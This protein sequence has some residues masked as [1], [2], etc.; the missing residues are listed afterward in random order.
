MQLASPELVRIA[1]AQLLLLVGAWLMAELVR[2]LLGHRVKVSGSAMVL[3]SLVAVC[4]GV[5]VVGVFLPGREMLDLLT[6]LVVFGVDAAALVG[7]SAVLVRMQARQEPP[8]ISELVAAGE[9]DHVEF[10]SSARW[11]LRT[12]KRDERMELVIAKTI[13]AF[14]NSSGGTLLIGVDDDG[15]LLGL[16]P[17]FTTLKQ[18]DPDRFE[19]WLRDLLQTKLGARVAGA[20]DVDFEQIPGG[21]YVCRVS[22]PPTPAP[23]FL[24]SGKGSAATSEL[25]VRIGNSSRCLGVDDAIGYVSHRWP[26]PL[27]TNLHDRVSRW[28]RTPVVVTAKELDD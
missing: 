1:I 7:A 8:S 11:N 16:G 15:R 13:A 4:L 5:A 25:W 23:V 2:Q 18:P 20:P 27:S 17:D 3:V 12:D 10:K 19:L 26:A 14:C 21:E 24:R 6:L 28:L 22:C 9:S